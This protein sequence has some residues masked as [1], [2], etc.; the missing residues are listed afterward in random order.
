MDSKKIKKSVLAK[1]EKAIIDG[2]REQE[3]S[4]DSV[5]IEFSTN[6]EY[7]KEKK[8][9]IAKYKIPNFHWEIHFCKICRGYD[10]KTPYHIEMVDERFDEK[11]MEK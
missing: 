7:L 6:R 3:Q 4:I 1:F 5:T 2:T 8:R 11:I 9:I 10:R